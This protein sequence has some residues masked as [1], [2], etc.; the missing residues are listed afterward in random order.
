MKRKPRRISIQLKLNALV[1]SSILAVALGLTLISYYV[2]CQRVDNEYYSSLERASKACAS[3]F[4]PE[5]MMYFW[6]S[7]NTEEY[8]KL[9]EQATK[10]GDEKIIE[11]WMLSKPGYFSDDGFVSEVA[12]E[13][14]DT[15]Q[16]QEEDQTDGQTAGNEKGWNLLDDYQQ[17]QYSL[18]AIKQ[19]FNVDC[20]YY[21]IDVDGVTYN[22]ADSN[23]N[24][25]YVG[26]VET[27]IEEFS[28]YADNADVPPTVHQSVYGWLCTAMKSIPDPETGAAI[29]CAGVDI[30][31]TEIVRVRYMFLRQSFLFVAILLVIAILSSVAVLRRTAI[32][33]L[34]QLA[35]ATARFAKKEDER[36]TKEDVLQLDLRSNDEITDLY[37]EIQSMEK[38]IVDNMEHITLAAAEKERVSTELRTASQIQSSMLPS[39]FPAFPDRGDFDLYASMTPAKEVG[40]DFYD[41]LLID[42]DHLAVLIAD[43]SDKGVPA[44][45]FMMSTKILLN[46]RAQQGGS[47][48]EILYSVNDQ[49]CKNNSEMFVTVWLGI[50]DLN[51]GVMTCANA[52]HEYPFI[53]GKDGAF[54]KLKDKHGIVLGAME[55]ARYKDYEIQMMPGDAVFV[56]T[57][58]IPEANNADGEFY[59][60][61]RMESALNSIADR[62]PEGVLQGIRED[63][64]SFTGEARQFDDLTMLCV[65]YK[66][67]EQKM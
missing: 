48:S 32:R 55:S 44:A 65:E 38:R 37:R 7:I 25:L 61:E 21:Q 49:I 15:V 4:A 18:T 16:N 45:L 46:Y 51:T 2:F 42:E 13:L 12:E 34:Q 8:R 28:S 24:L 58:G 1:I 14:E 54:R 43:V 40:G 9:R 41:F 3:N 59:G 60:L 31:M 52:G 56:Y 6:Q 19:Y 62:D 53:R 26:T 36:V 5:E 23:E 39:V 27:P 10:V 57:D 64:N 63:V 30:D 33:P 11:E 29:A 67:K 17:M 22:I 66:G 20:A 35:E 50:L 47:P